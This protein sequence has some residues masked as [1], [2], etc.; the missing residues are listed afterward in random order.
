MSKDNI[1]LYK[2]GERQQR[3]LILKK[4]ESK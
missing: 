2:K 1:F 3:I 4:D